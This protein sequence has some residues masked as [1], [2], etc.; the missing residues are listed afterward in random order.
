MAKSN[1]TRNDLVKFYAHGTAMPAYG[2]TW[3][4]HLHT[5]DPGLV[6]TS[7][8]NEATYTGYAEVPVSRDSAGWTICD[9]DGTP[10]ANGT[11]FKNT[12]EITWPECTGVSDD[13]IQ[14][15]LSI[16]NAAG[17]IVYKT[18]LTASIRVNN[19]DTPRAPAG[20]VIFKEG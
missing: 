9:P 18:A 10:N 11:A 13:E 7:A 14:T 12:A 4:A 1:A 5:A 17:Q 6:G 16:C 3:Y 2:S 15:H 20:T 19:Q 8:T